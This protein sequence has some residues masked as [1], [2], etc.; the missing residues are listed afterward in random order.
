MFNRAAV[1]LWCEGNEALHEVLA[2]AL[3]AGW[4]STGFRPLE[5]DRWLWTFA[6]HVHHSVRDAIHFRGHQVLTEGHAQAE[7]AWVEHQG[8]EP[9]FGLGASV[10]L[11]DQG[12]SR[13]GQITG[14]DQA[15]AYY[16]VVVPEWQRQVGLPDSFTV[17]V[18]LPYEAVHPLDETSRP[19]C[20]R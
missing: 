20:L 15:R 2:Q 11:P 18:R 14:I 16:F 10:W 4:S 7:Q 12:H 1:L 8:I 6:P 19:F 9:H 13:R 5:S 3:A 17:G